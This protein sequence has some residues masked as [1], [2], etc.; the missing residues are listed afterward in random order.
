MADERCVAGGGVR[1]QARSRISPY[2]VAPSGPL[3]APRPTARRRVTPSGNRALLPAASHTATADAQNPQVPGVGIDQLGTCA[4]PPHA[5][6]GHDPR[7]ARVL[8]AIAPDPRPDPTT[9][10]HRLCSAS[11]KLL[12][13]SGAALALMTNSEQGRIWASNGLADSLEEL[14]IGLGEGPGL[15][16]FQRGQPILEPH[17]GVES[18]RWP[19]FCPAAFE[20]GVAAVFAFPLR[21]GVIR[22]GSLTLYR[23]RP[24]CLTE[25]ELGDAL[26]LADL[27]TQGF[28]DLQAQGAFYW[29]LFDP[30]GERARLHQATGIIATQNDADM[31][32]ALA[33]IRSYAFSN[34]R[35]IYEV[36]DDVIDDRL[37]LKRRPIA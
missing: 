19:F 26:V 33:C 21:I 8:G 34:S 35:S 4:I 2:D 1:R 13:V 12:S 15:E 31:A 22:L 10:P 7:V 32:T 30:H 9:Y 6:G 17:V 20:L 27:A 25:A 23:D 14:Q 11:V 5:A 37:R 18:A 36:A 16:A 24:G 28:L 3:Q 29:R